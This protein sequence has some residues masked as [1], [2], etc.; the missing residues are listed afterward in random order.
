[1]DYLVYK[2][3]VDTWLNSENADLDEGAKLLVSLNRN[4]ILYNNIMR[5]GEKL[6]AKLEYELKK[7]SDIL[8]AKANE[9]DFRALT[10]NEVEQ[11]TSQLDKFKKEVLPII[12]KK[13]NGK[14]VDHD[15]LSDKAK[16]AFSENE[17]IY[18]KIRSLHE[19]L[20][21]MNNE[22]PCDRYPFLKQ[23]IAY[24]D[25]IR[26][27]WDIYDKEIVGDN[28][29]ADNSD[30]NLGGTGTF[31][32]TFSTEFDTNNQSNTS[33]TE[34]ES[35]KL[36]PKQVNSNRAYISR[37]KVKLLEFKTTGNTAGYEGLKA[38]MQLRFDAMLSSG[39]AFDEE[40]VQYLKDLGLNVPE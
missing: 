14:R 18:P 26:H 16:N 12:N 28:I 9:V 3:K 10:D 31:D 17:D 39:E 34:S 7:Q 27:N 24:D 2:E 36:T 1:M 21:L 38:N 4:K 30:A 15:L 8:G 25:L 40:T 35:N 11:M 23:L 13:T 22:K 37:N 20:K 29:Q 33:S 6:R 5:Q 19:K 32:E